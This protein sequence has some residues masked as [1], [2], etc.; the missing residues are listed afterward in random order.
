[1]VTVAAAAVDTKKES[2]LAFVDLQPP[3]PILGKCLRLSPTAQ[4]CRPRRYCSVESY[5]LSQCCASGLTNVSGNF[6]PEA[7]VTAPCTE[8]N[9]LIWRGSSGV[10]GA[11][12]SEAFKRDTN[13]LKLNLGVGAYRTE[14]L[15][16]YVLNVVK[17]ARLCSTRPVMHVPTVAMQAVPSTTRPNM[18]VSDAA[19]I[20]LWVEQACWAFG[21]FW[22]GACRQ[23]RS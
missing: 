10:R 11:G 23:R 16:P 9:S 17:K 21:R 20:W 3:D 7:S 1:M 13:D 19:G 18:M 2:R 14:E 8:P 22:S 4:Q 12:V 15:K 5:S 6:Q